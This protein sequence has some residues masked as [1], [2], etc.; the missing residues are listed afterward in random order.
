MNEK[1]EANNRLT[2]VFALLCVALVIFNVFMAVAVRRQIDNCNN[3]WVGEL[4]T[5]GILIIEKPELY[6]ITTVMYN[7]SN[8]GV[9]KWS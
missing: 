7:V 3:Y 6:N 1:K 9:Y 2:I 4:E 5:R 8:E